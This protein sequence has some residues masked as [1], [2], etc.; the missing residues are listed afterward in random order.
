LSPY[1]ITAFESYEKQAVL[2]HLI[3]GIKFYV[4]EAKINKISEVDVLK[5]R[6]IISRCCG[7]NPQD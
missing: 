5:R 2:A 6:N 4:S 1:S 7:P 3:I